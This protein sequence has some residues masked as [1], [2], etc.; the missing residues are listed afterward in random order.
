MAAKTRSAIRTYPL[1]TEPLNLFCIRRLPWAPVLADV[2][3]GCQHVTWL[4]KNR[5]RNSSVNTHFANLTR[6]NKMSACAP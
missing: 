4:Q 3:G 2:Q 5:L 1:E 6:P